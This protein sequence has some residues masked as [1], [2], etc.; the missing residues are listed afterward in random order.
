MKYLVYE[1]PIDNK[2]EF[3]SRISVAGDNVREMPDIR[4]SNG[5]VQIFIETNGQNFK[6]LL[7]QC[8]DSVQVCKKCIFFPLTCYVSIPSRIEQSLRHCF[9]RLPKLSYD[10]LLL[11]STSP[12]DLK[13]QFWY[14]L[15][16]NKQLC[17]KWK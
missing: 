7:Q 16:I 3:L 14:T 10:C 11:F 9:W 6:H 13:C 5:A 4:L 1:T 17:K 8:T 12:P 15:Q 2:M